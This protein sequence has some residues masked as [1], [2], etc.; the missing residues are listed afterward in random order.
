MKQLDSLTLNSVTDFIGRRATEQQDELLLLDKLILKNCRPHILEKTLLLS[1][2]LK[3]IEVYDIYAQYNLIEFSKTISKKQ[4]QDQL[5]NLETFVYCTTDDGN[6]RFPDKWFEC[7]KIVF[8]APEKTVYS[9]RIF[10]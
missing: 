6:L 9:I 5:K 3:E 1:H 7:K 4:T 2:D 8:K 10:Q